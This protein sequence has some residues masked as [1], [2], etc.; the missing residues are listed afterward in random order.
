MKLIKS[1]LA[2]TV[3]F[4]S[5]AFATHVECVISGTPTQQTFTP[6]NCF[7]QLSTSNGGV[8]FRLVAD[9]PI[10]HVVWSKSINGSVSN[11]RWSSCTG[12]N[13]SVNFTTNGTFGE[14]TACA[15]R[16]YY[17]DFTW[18]NLNACAYGNFFGGGGG[19]IGF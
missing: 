13:C 19:P 18:E 2:L 8:Y 12:S 3:L 17:K 10:D 5:S 4:S 14:A 9:K 1:I 6:D 16:V 7:S 11:V 15:T